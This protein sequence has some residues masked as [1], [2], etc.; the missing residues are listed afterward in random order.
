MQIR[1]TRGR[2]SDQNSAIL[3]VK[4][5][6]SPKYS[7]FCSS[8]NYFYDMCKK[9]ATL[10]RR[11]FCDVKFII[12]LFLSL[13]MKHKDSSTSAEA[14]GSSSGG[15]G[16][17]K[18]IKEGLVSQ[19]ASKFQQT[20]NKDIPTTN[21]VIVR[22]KSDSILAYKASSSSDVLP[23]KKTSLVS[24]TESHQ[25]RFNNARAMFEKMGSTDDLDSI[26]SGGQNRL[27]HT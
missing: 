9:L 4:T 27:V 24:R 7:R 3:C 14:G 26:S 5:E 13:Q 15:G 25:T 8:Q 11:Y 21:P 18:P 10:I 16:Y 20:N 17:S 1:T 6:F 2:K 23:V 22:K 12:F 19:I